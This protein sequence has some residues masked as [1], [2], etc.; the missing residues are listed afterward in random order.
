MRS[1]GDSVI[2]RAAVKGPTPSLGQP[3]HYG[4]ESAKPGPQSMFKKPAAGQR[5]LVAQPTRSAEKPVHMAVPE[6]ALVELTHSA[7]GRAMAAI[8]AKETA[9]DPDLASSSRRFGIKMSATALVIS[10]NPFANGRRPA[11]CSG[12]AGVGFCDPAGR[13]FAAVSGTATAPL[14]WASDATADDGRSALLSSFTCWC[15]VRG[16]VFGECELSVKFG[17]RATN[18]RHRLPL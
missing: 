15:A 4:L 2:L 3:D 18:S 13:K 7:R 10:R 5:P 16:S 8:C 9:V 11:P 14:P 1:R 6:G 17:E 12:E